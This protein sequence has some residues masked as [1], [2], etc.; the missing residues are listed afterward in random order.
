MFKGVVVYK[1]DTYDLLFKL[2]KGI[3][4]D[5]EGLIAAYDALGAIGEAE[6]ITLSTEKGNLY[7]IRKIINPHV[8][9]FVFDKE[10]DGKRYSREIEAISTVVKR[11]HQQGDKKIVEEL[12]KYIDSIFS[13]RAGA[14]PIKLPTN[15]KFDIEDLPIINLCDGKNSIRVIAAILGLREIDVLRVIRKYVEK[16][17]LKIRTGITF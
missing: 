1:K 2:E 11:V 6:T 14:F 13:P 9:L 7:V 15:K 4:L 5:V 10:N 16:N 12:K 3:E 17:M 8:I